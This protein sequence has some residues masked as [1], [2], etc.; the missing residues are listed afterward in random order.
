MMI[1]GSWSS[2]VVVSDWTA[3]APS[4]FTEAVTVAYGA[5]KA[6]IQSLLIV[7][8]VA[9]YKFQIVWAR[10]V[11]IEV[12]QVPTKLPCAKLILVPDKLITT[13]WRVELTL[14][15]IIISICWTSP[16]FSTVLPTR[17]NTATPLL[18]TALT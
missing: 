12:N 7:S 2:A 3:V 8:E 16:L 9:W 13:N 15:P 6:P 11:V 10:P 1:G 4:I 18:S 17:L 5:N 14:E